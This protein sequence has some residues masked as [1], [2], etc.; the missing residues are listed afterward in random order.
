MARLSLIL[1]TSPLITIC[2]FQAKRVLVVEHILSFANIT[3]VDTVGREATA[4]PAYKDAQVILGLLASKQIKQQVV[5]RHPLDRVIDAYNRLGQGERDTIRFSLNHPRSRV[6]L[7][8]YL[9]YVI[10]IRFGLRPLLFLDLLVSL[11]KRGMDESL[12]EAVL[13]A[14]ATRYSKPF[15]DHTRHKLREIKP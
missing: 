15:V 4:N 8:D 9:A 13:N 14:T 7:D 10:A 12:A 11:T 5:N 2:S 6:I 1:D 3:I